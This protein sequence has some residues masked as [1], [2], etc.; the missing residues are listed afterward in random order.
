MGSSSCNASAICVTILSLILFV[1]I[2]LRAF[3]VQTKIDDFSNCTNCLDLA[4]TS[5]ENFLLSMCADVAKDSDVYGQYYENNEQL[6]NDGVVGGYGTIT[7]TEGLGFMAG[8]LVFII[9][10][11]GINIAY[12]DV[13]HT[14]P[15]K[16]F[17]F[18]FVWTF[19][20]L[21]FVLDLKVA[22][23]ETY[24]TGTCWVL[25]VDPS[26]KKM[27][28]TVTNWLW[29]YLALLLVVVVLLSAL[30]VRCDQKKRISR[31]FVTAGLF[32]FIPGFLGMCYLLL[33]VIDVNSYETWVLFALCVIMLS[34]TTYMTARIKN[35]ETHAVDIGQRVDGVSNLSV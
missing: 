14:L 20:C 25:N 3:E 30:A 6:F 21:V 27:H 2:S 35:D 26:K 34:A 32:V 4:L 29:T 5:D 28:A 1:Y 16:M 8:A 9:I 17:M 23:E 24:E 10:G 15:P 7:Y 12:G 19:M 11:A 13:N 31:F 18:G 22:R 33:V